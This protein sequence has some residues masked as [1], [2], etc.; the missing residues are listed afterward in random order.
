MNAFFSYLG[1]TLFE[2]GTSASKVQTPNFGYSFNLEPQFV[3]MFSFRR[4]QYQLLQ[5]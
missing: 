3:R 4:A 1:T 2:H 5:S